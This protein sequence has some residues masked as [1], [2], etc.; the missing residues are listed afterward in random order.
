MPAPWYKI[1]AAAE[2]A[3][4]WLYGTIGRDPWTGDGVDATEFAQEL[5]ALN[6]AQL[7]V[8]IHSP[9]GYVGDGAAIF[10][11]I[12]RHPAHVTAYIDG[13]AAS[14]ASVIPMAADEIIISPVAMVMIHQPWTIAMGNAADM[15]QAVASLEAHAETMLAAYRRHMRADDD[16]IRAAMDA[17]TWYTAPQSVAAG[18]ATRIADH[19]TPA[20]ASLAAPRWLARVPTCAARFFATTEPPRREPKTASE[21]AAYLTTK[22]PTKGH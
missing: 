10:A 4:V 3:E 17:E 19:E 15:R 1:Q 14:M 18:L 7:D 12:D 22:T 16:A 11:A 9:G 2:R 21:L 20:A 8:R 6:V 5:A 13:L